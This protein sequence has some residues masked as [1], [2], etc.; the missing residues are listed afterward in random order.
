MAQQQGQ[1]LL[2]RKH[3][4]GSLA[5]APPL[6]KEEEP[7]LSSPPVPVTDQQ[8]NI[9]NNN[10]ADQEESASTASS[11]FRLTPLVERSLWMRLDVLP[12]F[13]AY[14]GLLVY[15][16]NHRKMA[17]PPSTN[18]TNTKTAEFS[19][20]ATLLFGA[21]LLAHLIV[22]VWTQ[23][24]VPG[25]AR[26]GFYHSKKDSS[27]SVSTSSSA[28]THCLVQSAHPEPDGSTVAGIVPV[29]R[30]QQPEGEATVVTVTFQDRVFRYSA[31]QPDLDTTLW[32]TNNNDDDNLDAQPKTKSK[33]PVTF[34]PLQYPI[35]MPLSFYAKDWK[36]HAS[37][38]S[39]QAAAQV[40]GR[41]S[42]ALQLPS[43]TE[44]LGVQLVAPFF[45]F[46]IFCVVLWSL[47]EYWYYALFTLLALL[48]FESTVAYNRL[49]SLERLHDISRKHQHQRI[50]VRRGTSPT[51]TDKNK[52]KWS[53]M[54]ISV[55][56]L[57]PGDWV[58]LAGHHVPVPADILLLQGTAVCDEALLTGESVPQL[59]Q[60]LDATTSPATASLDLQSHKES[61]LFGGTEL[62]VGTPPSND[63]DNNSSSPL[64][65][66]SP[67]SSA[68]R[69]DDDTPPDR[70]VT[71]MVLRTG[72][73]TAQGNLLR[74][75]AH[76]ASKADGVHTV[77]TFVF[78]LLLIACAVAAAAYVLKEG[79]HDERRNRFRLLLHVIIIITSVVPPE[80][81]MEL[82]LAV[83]NSVQ[84]LIHRCQVYCTEHFRIPWAGEVTVCCFDKTGTLTSD[85]MRLK[86]VRIFAA[87][88]GEKISTTMES[89]SA[90]EEAALVHPDESEL[91]WTTVR[92]MAACH[93]LAIAATGD[94]RRIKV[95]GDPLE[96]AVMKHTGYALRGNNVVAPTTETAKADSNCR[97]IIILHRFSFSS[98]VKRMTV[99]VSDEA[100]ATG[101][102]WAL[103]KGAPETIKELLSPDSVP[104][105]YDEVSFHHMSRGR[106][107]L[108][109]AYREV[110]SIR[111]LKT[112]KDG[113]RDPI[114]RSL[115][116]AGFLVLDCPL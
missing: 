42:T 96:Q 24:S 32:T 98:K 80:L 104:P 33:G 64:N 110:G 44:L 51:F 37:L 11:S 76:S 91:P 60:P 38:E 115:T 73:E 99:L 36:G 103:V 17:F 86:G 105:D 16:Q 9:I 59:K 70:G 5:G 6:L 77:D 57:L 56:E 108:A 53:W 58:S 85:E 3:G 71:G 29:V 114:E 97:L 28:W 116:F 55:P 68:T 7:S 49:K 74:T 102:V 79:W 62:V 112:F 63:D 35:Q 89:E 40:Y 2:N 50:W 72:F 66:L 31:T 83:T 107:V 87:K 94:G 23:W 113:G 46:Q 20:A 90:D 54:S 25:K 27:S 95:I 39:C 93:S 52:L 21:T 111:K 14:T 101:T 43:F 78:I 45:L 22:V 8:D 75:M 69:V 106:R 47:D 100:G 65:S 13:L 41:N 84:A 19:M 18:N 67:A 92:I 81:P 12:F 82:S 26:V 10:N 88:Q 30:Q 15:D 34:R 109:M 48:M 61:I 4:G 1:N